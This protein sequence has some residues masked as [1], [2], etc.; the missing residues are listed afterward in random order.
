MVKKPAFKFS[1]P[2]DIQKSDENDSKWRVKGIASTENPDLQ[3]EEVVQEGLDISLLKAG[4]GLFNLDHKKDPEYVLGQIED[5]NFIKYDG[6]TALEVEGYLFDKQP[7][8]QAMYNILRSVKKSNGPRVHMSI[9]GKVLERDAFNSKKIKKARIDK[10]ALTLD[11]VNPFTFADLAKS[12]N[13]D[14][15]LPG[16]SEI[17]EN[18]VVISRAKLEKLL[19]VVTKAL[20]AGAPSGAPSTRANGEV[21]QSESLDSKAKMV[22]YKEKKKKLDKGMVKSVIDSLWK[23]FPNRDPKE[24]VEMTIE[25]FAQKLEISKEVKET[26]ND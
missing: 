13:G 19:D 2:V 8:A 15:E 17:S 21:V 14:A 3:G 18:D 20:E 9:E 26:P 16:D 5:A 23:A 22:T 24:L 4:R 7:K 25:A 11:P 1:I 12:F 6:K 10:V